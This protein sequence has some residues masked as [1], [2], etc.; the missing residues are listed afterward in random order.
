MAPPLAVVFDNYDDPSDFPSIRFRNYTPAWGKGGL[1]WF[2]AEYE[3]A[4]SP[5]APLSILPLLKSEAMD[6]LR[7]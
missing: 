5:G 2:R 6:L 7:A 3:E 4:I 1:S